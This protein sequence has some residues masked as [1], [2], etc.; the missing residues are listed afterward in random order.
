MSGL[1]LLTKNQVNKR[2]QY[3]RGNGPKPAFDFT[4]F[5]S[6]INDNN[7]LKSNDINTILEDDQGLLWFA[8]SSGLSQYNWFLNQFNTYKLFGN[9]FKSTS[10]QNLYVDSSK[11]IWIAGGQKG[12]L[13]YDV[14]NHK[15]TSL[16]ER[17]PNL[18][19]D[20]Y[21]SCMMSPD[22]IHLY[23]ASTTGISILNLLTNK[24]EKF[25]FPNW[26]LKQNASVNI[27]KIFV[28]SQKRV[29]C[30]SVIGLFKISLED[31]DYQFIE[32]DQHNKNTIS[33]NTITDI[34][35]D[36]AG[37]I[38]VATANGL[39]EITIETDGALHFKRFQAD[40]TD[41]LTSN[42]ILSLEIIDQNLFIGSGDGLSK[43][44]LQKR[45]F[46]KLN[47]D[48]HKFWI[49]NMI[50]TADGEIWGSST[51]GLFQYEPKSNTFSLFDKTGRIR[52]VSFHV[53]SFALD[54]VGQIYF[55]QHEEITIFDPIKIIKNKVAPEVFIT[56]IEKIGTNGKSQLECI[57]Y[58]EVTID[59]NDYH[60][61]INFTAL[62]YNQSEKNKYAYILEGL[63]E[64]WNYLEKGKSV[65]YTNLTPKTYNFKVKACNNNDI[66]NQ[67][68]AEIKIIKQP[69]FWQ[70]WWFYLLAL[71]VIG[72]L[73]I[74]A[75]QLYTFNIRKNND[76]LKI[77]NDN[78]NSEIDE[79]KRV[80]RALEQREKFSRTIMDSVPQ[81]IYWVDRD[82]SILG[83]NYNIIRFLD[84]AS[85]EELKGKQIYDFPL[86]QDYL[87]EQSGFFRKVLESGKAVYNQISFS[88]ASA[89]APAMWLEQSYVPLKDEGGE[90]MG[91]LITGANI[92]Q[93]VQSEQLAEENTRKINQYNA[94]LRESNR[95]LEQFA[96][97]ASHDLK[98]PLRI[99]GNFSGLLAR[100]YK[101][102]LDA[103]ADE[104]ISY[105]Q[106]GAHRMSALIQ[107]LL[108]YSQIG[109]KSE[110]TYDIDLNRLIDVKLFDLSKVIEERN[111][112][113]TVENLPV[114]D[115]ERAQIGMIFYNLI[116][117]G[118]KFNKSARPR[119]HI[120]AVNNPD[121]S[122]WQFSVKDNGIGIEPIFQKQIFEIFKRLHSKH[123][124]DGTGIG[125]SVC[126]KII[127]RHGGQIWLES[128][129]GNGTTFHFTIAK[130][131][132][133]LK[134]NVDQQ[135]KN[136]FAT[137]HS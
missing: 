117:N 43:Y 14:I 59:A 133:N 52:E 88:P 42:R 38:W 61:T 113:V 71:F 45:Q 23:I 6:N 136:H 50:S 83:A 20:D 92:N 67:E 57:G 134:L 19:I 101:G 28:D 53:G 129:H 34:I 108:T 7:S 5:Y 124:Y 32:Y 10:R 75:V 1:S 70:T 125:L 18:L 36:H 4:N 102:K 109:K 86:D 85:T 12:M 17:H 116:N 100:N 119:V 24:V 35:E 62:N 123:D 131:L 126:Q 115:G 51:E 118:I 72:A 107:S 48:N 44:N 39:N 40:D 89:T 111:A 121:K 15:V 49:H 55:N 106:D 31:N 3:A 78:L 63:E 79:R 58:D 13:Q 82:F 11:K 65:I 135:S 25:A 9:S 81:F 46:E 130:D 73:V 122:L 112:E 95:D 47:L 77:L 21:V 22:D 33:D 128:E 84:L 74:G 104:F 8:S 29:W 110:V 94:E 68:G 97:I 105:I 41:A 99:I 80:E 87:N 37:H 132:S 96:Y 120:K 27:S 69:F 137:K 66:W 76:N 60:I 90:V 26:V 64:S 16:K 56:G 54:N 127:F 93:R 103:N 2:N 114:I 30:C 98:E 91:L